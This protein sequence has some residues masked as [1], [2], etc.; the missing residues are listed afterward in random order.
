MKYRLLLLL[1]VCL[2][3]LPMSASAIPLNLV[4][5]RKALVDLPTRKLP[6]A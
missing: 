1:L 3:G 4:D 2:T 5:M 6:E